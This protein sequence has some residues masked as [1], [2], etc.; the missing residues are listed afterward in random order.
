[1]IVA[2]FLL[3]FGGHSKRLAKVYLGE[4]TKEVTKVEIYILKIVEKLNALLEQ[5]LYPKTFI[6]LGKVHA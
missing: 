1:M 4:V 5:P 3:I 6:W 2:A